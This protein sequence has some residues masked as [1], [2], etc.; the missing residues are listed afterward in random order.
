MPLFHYAC[1]NKH[2]SKKFFRQ[3]AQAPAFLSCDQCKSPMKKLLSAPSSTS[4]IIVDNGFQARQVEVNPDI[5]EIN[6]ARSNKN[7]SQED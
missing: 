5:I 3:V 7:Y 4:K 1:E 2:S 6:Q